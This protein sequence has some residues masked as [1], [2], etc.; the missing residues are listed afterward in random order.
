MPTLA[1][2]STIRRMRPCLGT[3]VEIGAQFNSDILTVAENAISCAFSEIQLIHELLSFH[4]PHS[5]LTKLN[6]AKGKP[7]KLHRHSLRVLHLARSMTILSD[8]LFNCTV[9]GSLV[10]KGILP[11]HDNVTTLAFGVADDIEIK[12]GKA[13][14]KQPVK[15]TLDGIAKGYAVDCAVSA[16]RRQGVH[17]GWVNAG[18]DLRAFGE[19]TLP[20]QRRE[21]DG[22]FSAMGG[23][24][25][26]ALASSQVSVQ[27][28]ERFPGMIINPNQNAD[29]SAPANGV[30]SVMA[31]SAWRADALTKV[32]CLANPLERAVLINKLNGALVYPQ[33][34]SRVF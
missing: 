26:A 21:A 32:A 3:F 23:L 18:G 19:I 12:H 2:Q 16:L 9:G 5:D 1:R 29:K 14:L 6:Q 27:Y 8:G 22:S 28:D 11:N 13:R 10:E 33:M 30:W 24:N 17:T 20:I 25:N 15:I 34:P 4:A 7:V 31:H